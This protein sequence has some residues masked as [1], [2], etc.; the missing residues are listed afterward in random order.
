MREFEALRVDRY[1]ID[2]ELCD[3]GNLGPEL[4]HLAGVYCAS[5]R[6][7]L[8][9]NPSSD[10]RLFAVLLP[11]GSRLT[12]MANPIFAQ[13]ARAWGLNVR[14]VGIDRDRLIHDFR[15]LLTDR[16]L[17]L[18]IDWLARIDQQPAP[19]RDDAAAGLDVLFAA[20]AGEMLTVLE[21]GAATR[22]HHLELRH[23]LEPE[24]NGTL[25][26]RG[27]RYPDFLHGLRGALRDGIIDVEFYGRVL[28]SIDLRESIV[29]RRVAATLE[30]SLDPVTLAKL[31]HCGAGQHLGCYNW[32]RLA[33]RHAAAR[34]HV[35][36]ALPAFA[37]FFADALVPL[38][39]WDADEPAAPGWRDHD[40]DDDCAPAAANYDLPRLVARRDAA[41]SQHWSAVLRRAVDA[42]QDRHVITALARRFAVDA[43]VIRRLWHE[44]PHELAQPPAWQLAQILR[45]LDGRDGRDWPQNETQWRALLAQAVPAEAA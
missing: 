24:V 4:A 38:E 30:A 5:P 2:D 9:R 33:P 7:L 34:A 11:L 16:T 18:L 25:F 21:R 12:L 39:T 15:A 3:A 13:L 42:G 1:P 22:F 14:F 23:R 6:A 43:N 26:E 37:S 10:W 44:R 36:G 27:T 20:L 29:E 41:H 35:L 19:R 32:L 17:A 8:F 40:G 28:R 31:A 45:A